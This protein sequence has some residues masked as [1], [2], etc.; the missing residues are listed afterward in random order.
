MHFCQFRI[1]KQTTTLLNVSF[2][3]DRII[4][5]RDHECR[6]KV[7][8]GSPIAVTGRSGIGASPLFCM[9]YIASIRRGR[10]DLQRPTRVD[11]VRPAQH[12]RVAGVIPDRPAVE[13]QRVGRRRPEIG[14]VLAAPQCPVHVVEDE[15]ARAADEYALFRTGP[16]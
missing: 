2:P 9:L 7:E 14:R 10:V 11:V 15:R 8:P 16:P 4:G 1:L 13:L 6:F 3:A 12:R 5:T